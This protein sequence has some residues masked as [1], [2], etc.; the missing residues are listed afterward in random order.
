M[1][2]YWQKMDVKE[3]ANGLELESGGCIFQ[4]GAVKIKLKVKMEGEECQ[5][6]GVEAA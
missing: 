6:F 5:V 1:A 3:F 4:G 2:S